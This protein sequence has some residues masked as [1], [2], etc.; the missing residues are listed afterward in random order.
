MNQQ[1]NFTMMLNKISEINNEPIGKTLSKSQYAN[2]MQIRSQARE[3]KIDSAL[4]ALENQLKS[5][6]AQTL[7][8]HEILEKIPAV[9]KSIETILNTARSSKPN[10]TNHQNTHDKPKT[11][12][13]V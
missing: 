7:L 10:Q 12:G 4:H 13:N 1:E 11:N 9:E 5:M 6:R 8:P 2:L 3:M